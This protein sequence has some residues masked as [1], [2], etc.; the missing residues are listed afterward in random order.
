MGHPRV[1]IVVPTLGRRR[2]WLR[3]AVT[4]VL[5]QE[6]VDL[7]LLI[8]GPQEDL[9]WLEEEDGAGT[10]VAEGRLAIV[11]ETGRSLSAAINQGWSQL[12]P[13][14]DYFAWLGDDDALTAGSLA[15]SAS[16]L[17]AHSD[18]GFVYGRTIYI[19]ADG[20][21]IY[22]GLSGRWAFQY[23]RMGQDFIAQPGSLLRVS[24]LPAMEPLVDDSLSNAMDLDLFLRLVTSGVKA[25]FTRRV[26]SYYRIH[27]AAI[28][29]TKGSRD[30]S[31]MVRDRYPAPRLMELWSHSARIRPLVERGFVWSA[32][33][34]PQ[35]GIKKGTQLPI[36]A[37]RSEEISK[38]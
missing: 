38:Q 11:Q 16:I 33:H 22:R 14:S 30:E 10:L 7:R 26:Q 9:R 29:S 17:D 24:A 1:G 4:S 27:D 6:G 34:L 32:W 3:Q 12:S 18:V 28:T 8:V 36:F 20:R 35:P 19:D 21:L 2:V 31:T 25:M 23:L 15:H 37:E 5:H 13:N